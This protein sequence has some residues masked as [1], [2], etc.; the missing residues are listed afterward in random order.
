MIL[1]DT[2]ILEEIGKGT[3]VIKP[4]EP[5]WLGSNSY[6]LHLGKILAVY[7][8]EELDVKKENTIKYLEIP[9]EGFLLQPGKL[10]L[11]VTLEYTET[12]I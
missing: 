6:D 12:H 11:G 8:E 2:E 5:K 7:T 9:E 4:F 3:I 1:S 10:Y